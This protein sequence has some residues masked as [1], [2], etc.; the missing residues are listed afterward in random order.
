MG[1]PFFW[2]YIFLNILLWVTQS[3]ISKSLINWNIELS[4]EI[5]D[6]F[7][8]I[9]SCSSAFD[10]DFSFSTI[11]L[12]LILLGKFSTIVV[13]GI[14]S[15]FWT[16]GF[17]S[18]L[19]LLDLYFSKASFCFS[20]V[21]VTLEEYSS[22][23]SSL[24][25]V[26]NIWISNFV[27]IRKIKSLYKL[28]FAMNESSFNKFSKLSLVLNFSLDI[29]L[30]SIVSVLFDIIL[31]VSSFFLSSTIIFVAFFVNFLLALVSFSFSFSIF[32]F[33]IFSFS[34]LSCSNFSCF[35][36]SCFSFS[37]TTL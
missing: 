1:V 6:K 20:I 3:V 31:F 33:S 35:S 7:V 37:L 28:F 14:S 11:Y 30:S 24:S 2:G 13:L 25:S 9:E 29:F 18:F 27:S 12:T 17:F 16:M 36:F 19:F 5:K 10:I 34:I 4:Q 21:A 32:S 8:Y 15:G 26:F 23:V 22:S